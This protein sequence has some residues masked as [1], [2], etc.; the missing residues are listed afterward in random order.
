MRLKV[1]L[2][3]AGAALA[4]LLT[5]ALGIGAGPAPTLSV[6]PD[7]GFPDKV[8]TLQLPH[9]ATV[10]PGQ[11]SVTENGDP[12]TGLGVAAPGV[13][14]G[15]TLLVDASKSMTGKPIKGAMNAAR[16]FMAERNPDL[17]VAVVAFNPNVNVLTDF[18]TD[19]H[20]LAVAV[21]KAPPL[22]YGTH[23]YD[24]LEQVAQMAQDKGF[25]RSTV[26]LLSDGQELG[27]NATYAEALS[28]LQDAHVRV[29]SVG[30]SSRFFDATTLKNL[31]RNT[32]GSY[33]EAKSAAQLTPIYTA[34]GAKLSSEYT[35]SYRSLLPPSREAAV[36]VSVAGF[37][38][39]KATYTTPAINF[40]PQGTFNQGWFD[41]VVASPYLMVFVIV[42]VLGLLAFAVISAL[43]VRSRSMKRRMAHYVNIPSEEEGKAR[44]AEV[45]AMLAERAERKFR[46]YRW[47]Q[48]FERDVEIADFS[49]SPLTLLGWTLIG[50]VLGS[51]VFAI[52]LHSLWGLLVGLVAPVVTRYVVS[53][54]L[55]RLRAAFAEQLP[56]NLD[57]LAGALRSGHSLVGAMGV[58][59]DGAAEPSQGEFRRVMQDEQLGVPID[60]ALMVMST[61]MANEDLEQVSLVTRLSREAGGNTAEVLDRV[62]D[63]IRG[64]MDLR[65]LV[66]VL[67]A[68]GKMARWILT[69]LP[70]VL[71]GWILVINPSWLNPLWQTTLGNAALVLW[72]V[73]LLIGS[74]MLKK[75]TEIVV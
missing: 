53:T 56:D 61:R 65:R 9:S 10:K 72:V 39:A 38:P 40:S 22:A 42:A 59:V 12:V 64:K 70:V 41:S 30:L 57:V 26:V 66:K 37:S 67:T 71:A 3:V 47:W 68:Q 7:S 16:A 73:L 58:M 63:N 13:S 36:K 45:G 23:V 60:E 28:A 69:A 19:K 49:A 11:V 48:S 15:V 18:S 44:R 25:A 55:A 62:V 21:G 4:A 1:G 8:Y 54:R 20:A 32:G 75:I 33:V 5:A 50:G 14:N 17:P 27:S 2:A 35:V 31:A 24:A 52:L 29:I 43:D 51:M 46:S 6:S 34:I 74:F